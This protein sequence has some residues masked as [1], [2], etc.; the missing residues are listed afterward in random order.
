MWIETDPPAPGPGAVVAVDLRLGHGPRAESVPRRADCTVRFIARGPQGMVDVPGGPDGQPAGFLRP[1]AGLH[2]IAYES[3]FAFS[4]LPAE[5]FAAYLESSGLDQVVAER[6]L[7]G[8]ADRP[9]R[10]RYARALK[11][12]VGVGP[13][14][15]GE[16]RDRRLGLPLEL[17]VEGDLGDISSPPSTVVLV[18][19]QGRPVPGVQVV[20]VPRPAGQRS[21]FRPKQTARTDAEGR[22]VFAFSA[23]SWLLTA[24]RSRRAPAGATRTGRGAGR[25]G[26]LVS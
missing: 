15:A 22:V 3:D 23:G 20:A 10:E 5:R 19:R 17:L 12:L 1:T 13:A 11:H 25:V 26:D 14:V 2:G 4:E 6:R 7:A 18:D 9:G 8:E 21:A 16:W 24:V